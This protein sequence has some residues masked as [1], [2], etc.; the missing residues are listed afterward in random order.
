MRIDKFF[1]TLDRL[2]NGD[3]NPNIRVKYYINPGSFSYEIF[4]QDPK[5]GYMVFHNDY[6]LYTSDVFYGW[7]YKHERQNIIDEI[8]NKI[9]NV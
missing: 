2:Y 8:R 3:Y 5:L 1:R 9:D 4:K 6:L 7:N